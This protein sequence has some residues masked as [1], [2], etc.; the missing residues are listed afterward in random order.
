MIN[1]CNHLKE[2]MKVQM[3]AINQA[4]EK[5]RYYLAETG[6]CYFS[7][8]EIKNDFFEK[9]LLPYWGE[10]FKALYCNYK[11]P[12]G[13]E[14]S[15]GNDNSNLA[16]RFKIEVDERGIDNVLSGGDDTE[17][18]FERYRRYI[19]SQGASGE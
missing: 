10:I 16:S 5:H 8:E 7:M 15:I 19:E 4:I 11:C 2:F 6:S 14:C 3:P 12:D 18:V 9:H 13:N 1:S 17:A